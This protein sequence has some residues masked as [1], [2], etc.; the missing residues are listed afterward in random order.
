MSARNCV[1]ANVAPEGSENAF[2]MARPNTA[3]TNE[4]DMLRTKVIF[5][6]REKVK[7]K[8]PGTNRR[9]SIRT[10]PAIW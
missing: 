9:L 5:I 4:K 7:E 1:T 8:K 2:A 10:V 3:K 6:F